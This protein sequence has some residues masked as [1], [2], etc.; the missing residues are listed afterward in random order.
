MVYKNYVCAQK[1]QKLQSQLKYSEPSVVFYIIYNSL[2][3]F[4][5]TLIYLK[6][7]N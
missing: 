4:P 3:H 1:K 5:T 2:F 7:A 6:I